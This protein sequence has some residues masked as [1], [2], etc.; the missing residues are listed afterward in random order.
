MRPALVFN[1]HYNGLAIIRELGRRGVP[2]YAL[3]S[4]RSIGRLSRYARFSLCP[5]PLVSENAFIDSLL[6]MGPRF[7]ERPVLFPTNDHWASAIS[8]HKDVLS[9]YYLPCVAD[10]S[11]VDLAIHKQRFGEWAAERGY[12][13]PRSWRATDYAAIRD[14]D[15]PIAAKPEYRRISANETANRERSERFDRARLTVLRNRA[16]LQRFLRDYE[17]VLDSVLLQ[18]YVRGQSDA[19]YTVGVYANIAHEVLGLF[20]GRKVRGFPPDVGDC[21]LGQSEVLP[22]ELKAMTRRMCR[23]LGYH[24]IAEFEFKRDTETGKFWL[25]EVNPR[26]WSWVGITPACGV[27]LPWIAYADLAGIQATAP[28]ESAAR[29]GGVKYVK[30]LEDFVHCIDGNRRAGYA[31]WHMTAREWWRS[32]RADRLVVAEFAWD[33]PLPAA[34]AIRETARSLAAALARGVAALGAGMV[35]RVAGG[36]PA[37]VPADSGEHAPSER[38]ASDGAAP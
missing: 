6:E 34:S 35:G 10:W 27:S 23:E 19:M 37:A 11:A 30:L 22:H 29:T 9:S 17:D 8:R 26:S 7:A 13:V 5:D 3:D 36:A 24:G 25:I 18:H 15:F 21:V 38:A 16:E 32:L 28:I 20:T 1:C 33:D 31:D 4:R 2:V 14:S 12:P